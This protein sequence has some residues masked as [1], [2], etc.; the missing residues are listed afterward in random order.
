VALLAIAHGIALGGGTLF[1]LALAAAWCSMRG[2]GL[3]GLRT[4]SAQFDRASQFFAGLVF[5]GL[6]FCAL[7]FSSLRRAVL[8]RS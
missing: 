2:S 4:P 7:V 3:L 8:R 1:G 6:V 5:A